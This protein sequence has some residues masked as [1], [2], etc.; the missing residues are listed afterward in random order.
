MDEAR[1]SAHAD[2]DRARDALDRGELRHAADHLAGAIVQAPTLPEIHELL[3]RLAARTDG[4]LGLF[5]LEQHAYVGAVVARAH[6]LA[7][8]GRPEQGLPLL[9]AATG[10]TP[11][12]D[13][14][15]VPWVSD[16]SLGAR[17]EPGLLA[18]IVMQLCT[19]VAD[20]APE[21]YRGAL[22]PYL[23]VLRNAVAVH[24]RHPLLL[25]AGSALAR[26]LGEAGLAVEWAS[27][28]AR[29][30]PSKLAEIWLGYAYRSAGRTSE[31]V[32]ALR[33]A[34]AHDPDD[35]SVYADIA[36]TL[37]D[38]GRMGQAL[39]WIDRALARDPAYDCAV[40]T[41]HR[42]RYQA[43]GDP[44]HLIRLA[45]FRR[46]HPDD[47]HEHTDLAD[48]CLDVP[49]LSRVPSAG[50]AVADTLRQLLAGE[51]LPAGGQSLRLS[52][53]ESPSALR[54]LQI[55][56]P[57]LAVT[58]ERVPTPD[59]REP[60]RPDGRMLW[61]YDGTTATPAVAPPSSAATERLRRLVEPTWPHPPAA[62]DAAVSLALV[63]AEDLLALLVHPP[64]PAATELGRALAAY[65]PACWV[66]SAQVWAC[67][68]LLHHRTD[69][70][71]ATS[72][73]R[74]LLVE[75]VW[76]VEDWTTEAAM[77]ALV[78]YAW[79][80]PAV[81]ADVAGLVAERLAEIARVAALRPVPIGWSV[82]QLALVTPGLD[83]AAHRQALAVI[84]D[85][86]GLPAP[87]PRRAAR[88]CRVLRWLTRRYVSR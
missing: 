56:A 41:G 77:F 58:V 75:L 72:T 70:A 32:A 79:V 48:C 52:A 50:D 33:R 63:E 76:G 65:D 4:G 17:L 57:W 44:V 46:E 2:L 71:W 27:R 29:A 67:L 86:E 59:I 26:R 37:A 10:H 51:R 8:A 24:G 85:E 9:A 88:A 84:R 61:H 81:R 42:L 28:G 23:T 43:D 38:G 73:R 60:C 53:P 45:D 87:P 36:G 47:S 35:L 12:A 82:A 13:W 39:R 74:R 64:A 83:D 5:P 18:R 20:P 55:A 19:V 40:H 30:Q 54:T 66:R 80:E 21:P 31:A 69:E 34:I 15:G 62:Y 68:G 3:G 11:G 6:L 14:A 25:G 22:R 49:W 7:A 1:R 16:P 78:T